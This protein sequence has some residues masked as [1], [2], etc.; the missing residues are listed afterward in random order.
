MY[1]FALRPRW[2]ISHIFVLALVFTMV[3]LGLWQWGKYQDRLDEN[4]VVSARL[5]EPTA[6]LSA[7]LNTEDDYSKA[8]DFENRPIEVSGTYLPD[9]QVLIRGRSLDGSPGSWVLTP[10]ATPD[11]DLAIINRGWIPNNG[12]L[13]AV[14]AKYAPLAGPVTVTGLL[15]PTVTRG[16]IGATDPPN[17]RLDNLARLDIERLAQQL[18][19][20]VLPAWVQLRSSTPQLNPGPNTPRVLGPPELDNG[21]YFSY[22]VQWFIFGSIALIGYPLILRRNAREKAAERSRTDEPDPP[23]DGTSTGSTE[24]RAQ[25]TVGSG[26]A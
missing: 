21:P 11:G 6:S 1:R 16:A 23:D 19:Q 15:H 4:L 3:N 12:A 8:E 17:G 2:I 7:L 26:G 18:D 9:Q 14:P 10:L 25:E 13:T 24:A 5:A 20:P 22:T